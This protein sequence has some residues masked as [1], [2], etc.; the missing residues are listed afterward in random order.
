MIAAQLQVSSATVSNA[1]KANFKV[2]PDIQAKIRTVAL[3]MGYEQ[4]RNKNK[5]QQSL[6][7]SRFVTIYDIA[8]HL[9]VSS[10]TV[11]RAL[12]GHHRVRA[13]TIKVVN[14]TAE[15]MGFKRNEAAYNLVKKNGL[16]RS[17]IYTVA[18]ALGL[19]PSTVS[20]AFSKNSR[21]SA[22]TRKK[23]IAKA[24]ELNFSLNRDALEL[25]AKKRY[26]IVVLLPH[27]TDPK[28]VKF[29]SGVE[30]E[31]K[32]RHAQIIAVNYKVEDHF[33]AQQSLVMF[34]QIAD[35]F[36][37]LPIT[38][39][40][41]IAVSLNTNKPLVVVGKAPRTETTTGMEIDHLSIVFDAALIL[42]DRGCKRILLAERNASASDFALHKAAFT[43]ALL[44]KKMHPSPGQMINLVHPWA[45]GGC[46]AAD[47]TASLPGFDGLLLINQLPGENDLLH[48][49]KL[50][51]SHIHTISIET[52]PVLFETDIPS[53]V[54]MIHFPYRKS[55]IDGM[56]AL[57]NKIEGKAAPDFTPK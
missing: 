15:R 32:S 8:D 22:K 7:R 51:Y 57:A 41:I 6:S 55:G 21:V 9:G 38:G 46:C 37:Y 16:E 36:L 28:T 33:D 12:N 3:E 14:E 10:A 47:L 23:V 31:A 11:S 50:G 27:L 4:P 35:G 2:S 29:L 25:I 13:E 40:E 44:R 20:R 39:N 17:T 30:H 18:K 56:T 53:A 24:S 54:E 42:Q 5:K 1:L 26:T 48:L 49:A 34:E 45:N 19:S 52:T 43:R